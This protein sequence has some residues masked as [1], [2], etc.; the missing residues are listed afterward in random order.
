MPTLWDPGPGSPGCARP[1]VP[2]LGQRVSACVVPPP[3]LRADGALISRWDRRKIEDRDQ[4]RVGLCG[5]QVAGREGCALWP[6]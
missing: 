1:D 3:G 2:G 6:C 4:P 5:E